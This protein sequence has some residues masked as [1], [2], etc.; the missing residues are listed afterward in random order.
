MSAHRDTEK[1]LSQ[2][3][4]LHLLQKLGYKLLAKRELDAQRRG[5]LGNV[6][7]E[8]ILREQLTRLNRVEHRG[9]TYPFSEANIETAIERLRGHGSAGLLR[10]NEA[11]TDL[12]QLGIS[13]NQTIEGE[14]RG[15]QLRYIDWDNPANN[16]FHV[17]KEFDVARTGSQQTCRPDIV[18]FVNGLPFCVVEC[19]GP[20]ED[21]DQGNAPWCRTAVC[22]RA[23]QPAMSPCR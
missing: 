23:C 12:L 13:L 17:A 22:R 18:L 1:H 20:R 2:I 3:P 16:A 5:K 9:A 8:D 15:R 14:T 7:L 10:T 11:V 6:L 4:A 21:L 19:K